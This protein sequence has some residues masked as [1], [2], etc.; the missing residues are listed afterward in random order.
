MHQKTSN[1]L[2]L[3][4]MAASMLLLIACDANTPKESEVVIISSESSDPNVITPDS[5]PITDISSGEAE[6]HEPIKPLEFEA[7]EEVD[8][9]FYRR[10]V[11][12]EGIPSYQ[13]KNAAT[14]QPIYLPM[15]QTVIYTGDFDPCFYERY[16]IIYTQG[17]ETK[18]MTQ[19]QLY[20][21]AEGLSEWGSGSGLDAN[22]TL[23]PNGGQPTS[24]EQ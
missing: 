24:N 14:D 18:S 3:L 16:T 11:N 9:P 23:G 4:L 20:V 13:V 22:T 2:L 7:G 17:G 6:L 8:N 1:A 21:N 19:F 5:Y 15:G 12:E 10:T